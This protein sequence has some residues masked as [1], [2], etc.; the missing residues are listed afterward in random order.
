MIEKT[1]LQKSHATV[2]LTPGLWIRIRSDPDLFAGSGSESFPLNPDPGSGSFSSYIVTCLY[3]FLIPFYVYIVFYVP[4]SLVSRPWP[5]L[6][7]LA[8]SPRPY[9]CT[10]PYPT[11]PYPPIC[12]LQCTYNQLKNKR[13]SKNIRV[14]LSVGKISV[15]C[16]ISRYRRY[17]FYN[18]T[19]PVPR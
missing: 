11:H 14:L 18:G 13:K 6:P 10:Y 3:N 16:S 5:P 8:S 4:G 7:G 1:Q 2:P 12:T 15:L 17:P 19:V 9:P